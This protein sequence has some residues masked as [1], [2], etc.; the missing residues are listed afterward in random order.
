MATKKSP[1][2]IFKNRF[3]KNL[4]KEKK[5][6]NKKKILIRQNKKIDKLMQLLQ[7]KKKEI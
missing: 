5:R 4:N 1:L 6:Y 2:R 3:K 7:K